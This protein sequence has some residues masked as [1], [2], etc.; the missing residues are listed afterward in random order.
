MSE[1]CNHIDALLFRVD[2]AVTCGL[3]NPS[4][5]AKTCEWLPNRKEVR[6]KNMVDLVR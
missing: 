1:T 2:A 6:P 3:T 4:C 5:T